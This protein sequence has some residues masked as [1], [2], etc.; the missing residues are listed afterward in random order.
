[1]RRFNKG[2]IIWISFIIVV[3]ILIMSVPFI[4]VFNYTQLTLFGISITPQ[5]EYRIQ[6]DLPHIKPVTPQNRQKAEAY[7]SKVFGVAQPIFKNKNFL[8]KPFVDIKRLPITN[9]YTGYIKIGND[10]IPFDKVTKQFDNN[11]KDNKSPS[12]LLLTAYFDVNSKPFRANIFIINKGSVLQY[13]SMTLQDKNDNVLAMFTYGKAEKQFQ[14]S[15]MQSYRRNNSL[16]EK[17][18]TLLNNAKGSARGSVLASSVKDITISATSQ[19]KPVHGLRTDAMIVK[20][21]RTAV[22]TINRLSLWSWGFRVPIINAYKLIYANLEYNPASIT[23]HIAVAGIDDTFQNKYKSAAEITN[24]T[25]F[26]F[27]QP[28]GCFSRPI[29]ISFVFQDV[30]DLY[31]IS[32]PRGGIRKV[33]KYKYTVKTGGTDYNSAEFTAYPCCGSA[34]ND[35]KLFCPDR[36]IDNLDIQ[37]QGSSCE[38]FYTKQAFLNDHYGSNFYS[39]FTSSWTYLI[40]VSVLLHNADYYYFTVSNTFDNVRL[41]REV[42]H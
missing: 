15:T 30:C 16:Q 40:S 2:S 1:M 18:A 38:G 23:V 24:D 20:P 19:T 22:Y 32:V 36:Q 37:K 10:I 8:S 27:P 11:S 9:T 17:S 5:Q 33:W 31:K 42:K 6:F 28:S 35:E 4:N 21:F 41:D 3:T 25:Q 7:L 26:R 12:K 13:A 29:N 14:R 34:W 39:R